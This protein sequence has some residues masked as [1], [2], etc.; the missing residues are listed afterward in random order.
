MPDFSI[1][2]PKIIYEFTLRFLH[3]AAGITWIGLLYWFN[4]VNVNFQKT[5]EADLKPKVNPI[6]ILPTLWYFRWAAAL[7]WVTG[8]LYFSNILLGE[9]IS[10]MG[11]PMMI[12]LGTV[13]VSYAIIF[14]LTRPEG[15][16]NNG[17]LLAAVAGA[18]VIAMSFVI[19][20]A[21]DT[22]GVSTNP[23]YMIGIGG[24]IGTIMLLNVWGIIWP[25]QKRILGLVPLKEGQDKAKLARRV[26]LASRTN[27][28]L[29][30]PMLFFMGASSHLNLIHWG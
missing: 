7:T 26:F 5:L 1:L 14:F 29:S 13:A 25:S 2:T 28:W 27:A 10:G 3:I 12:W 11:K 23:S 9:T 18:V 4:L 16:L 22:I 19:N 20:K 17:Y 8:F 15:P 21:F 6:L 24:A 30:L